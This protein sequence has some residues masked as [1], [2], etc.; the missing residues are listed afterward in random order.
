MQEKGLAPATR[1]AIIE[2]LLTE[3][4]DAARRPR[5]HP[6]GQGVPA[7]DV[8]ARAG[9]G[10]T[11]PRRTDRRRNTSFSQMEKACWPRSLHV[12]QI[13][14]MTERMVKKA[15]NTT[16]TPSRDYATL[17][18][19]CPNCG[20][21]V[22]ENYR[23]LRAWAPGAEPCGFSFAN[24]P[25]AHLETAEPTPCCATRR[26]ACWRASAPRRAGPSRPRSSS[27]TTTRRTTTSSNSTLATTR[28][29]KSPAR[30]WSLKTPRSAPAP[31]ADRKCTS[32][33]ATTC[34][35]RP[36]PPPRSPRP[37]A[38]SRAARSSCS[39]RWSASR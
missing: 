4:A 37:A 17:E 7:D 30:S 24:R 27:S 13:A 39:S 38:P 12:Q 18:S 10:G 23:R 25:Q 31:S 33:A 2:G 32:T 1:A 14:A 11:L 28:K 16:A 22:K 29:A 35:A 5:D 9:S 8:A 26:S 6:H 15:G 21:V 20:G 3:S 19:P 36:C 34:A